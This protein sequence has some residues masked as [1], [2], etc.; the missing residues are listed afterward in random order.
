MRREIWAQYGVQAVNLPTQIKE[1]MD[2]QK[3]DKLKTANPEDAR[4]NIGVM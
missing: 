4:A 1:A 2:K 3:A